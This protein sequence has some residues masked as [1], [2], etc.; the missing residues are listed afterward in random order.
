MTPAF[1]RPPRPVA[2]D[3]WLIE[4]RLNGVWMAVYVVRGSDTLAVVDTGYSYHPDS[5]ILPGLRQLG[6]A[7]RDVGLIINTH[8]HPDH[9]GGNASLQRRTGATICLH[10]LD[11]PLAAGPQ[12]H[13]A[14]DT[15]HIM[16]M[17]ALG[18]NDEVAA[19]EIFINERVEA[20]TVGRI[21]ADGDV[22]DLGGGMLL[23]TVPAPGHSRGSVAFHIETRRLAI[24]GDAVQGWGVSEPVLP[25]FYDPPAYAASLDRIARLDVDM[26]CLGHDVGWQKSGPGSSPIRSGDEIT[27]TIDASRAFVTALA[28]AAE[29]ISNSASLAD[30]VAE[31]A[32][33]LTGPFTVA[34][35]E[36]GRISATSAATIISQLRTEGPA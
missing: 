1:E 25:L 23:R 2:E 31:A 7:P 29:G 22:I 12:A 11:L 20:C 16:A 21:L 6:F 30:R 24:V 15:D 27:A 5:V 26:L 10:R 34:F 14:S 35:D 13:I 4:A 18:W 19:R 17:R 36:R 9:M 33:R 28:E 3:I 8:G 32:R